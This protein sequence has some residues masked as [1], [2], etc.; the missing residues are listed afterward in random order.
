MISFHTKIQIRF[1]GFSRKI[2]GYRR[3]GKISENKNEPLGLGN[4]MRHIYKV[5]IWEISKEK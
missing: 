5:V 4:L 1:K 2:S 3:I